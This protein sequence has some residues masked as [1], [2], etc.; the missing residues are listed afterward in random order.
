MSSER[1]LLNT[2]DPWWG[3]HVH[4]YNEVLP[5]IKKA[6]RILDLACGTGFGSNILAQYTNGIVIGGDIAVDAVKESSQKWQRSNLQFETLDGTK[7][8]YEEGYFDKIIS[9]ETIEHTTQYM[10]MLKEFHRVLKKGGIAFISTPNFFVNSPSGKVTNPYHTQEFT[11]EEL[12]K[13]LE[14]VFTEITI[15]GQKY[16]RY[17]NGKTNS[18]GKVIEWVFNIIGI[19]KLPY[20]IKTGV[21]KFFTGKPFYPT[22]TDF[23]MVTETKQ[24]FACKTFFCICLK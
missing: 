12:K 11:Y 15:K 20:H 1:Q 7:L 10:E 22:D 13:I 3:E 19:R 23:T 16:S 4:R 17:D 9:F 18:F 2:N 24:I 21:S 14:A 5:V 6:D 8:P